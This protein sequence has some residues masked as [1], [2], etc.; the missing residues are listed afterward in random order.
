MNVFQ[1]DR[2]RELESIDDKLS[3][4]NSRLTMLWILHRVSDP[5]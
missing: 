2:T 1:T 3:N 5:V 4:L